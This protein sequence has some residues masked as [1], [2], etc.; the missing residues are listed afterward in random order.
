MTSYGTG[1]KMDN[2]QMLE[3]LFVGER[4]T[5]YIAVCHVPKS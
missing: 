1:M 3:T 4:S 2:D 5:G